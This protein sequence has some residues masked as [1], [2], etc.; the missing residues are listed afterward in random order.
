MAH[1]ELEKLVIAANQPAHNAFVGK[2]RFTGRVW[3]SIGGPMDQYFVDAV[4]LVGTAHSR[5]LSVLVLDRAPE[6]AVPRGPGR[7]K[8]H[9]QLRLF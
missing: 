9:E 1:G 5:I 8:P 2:Q 6:R 3:M 7:V 4:A